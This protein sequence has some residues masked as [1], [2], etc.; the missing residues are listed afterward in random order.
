MTP[1]QQARLDAH[2]AGDCAE[3]C[4]FHAEAVHEWFGLSYGNYAVLPRTLL[5]AM[6]GHWQRRFVALLDEMADATNGIDQA[7]QYEVRAVGA[8]HRYER[9]PLPHYRRAPWSLELLAA[10]YPRKA[11]IT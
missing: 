10:Q 4:D 2:N 7:I 3:D 9:D 6:P 5:Q 1:E 11:R 8:G